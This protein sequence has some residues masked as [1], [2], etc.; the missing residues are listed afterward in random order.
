MS[1]SDRLNGIMVP[2]VT[3]FDTAGDLASESARGLIERHLEVGVT[4]FYIGGSSGEGFLQ[5]VAERC[6][7]MKFVSNVV[8][9]RAIMIAQVG[10]LSARDAHTLAS[11]AA[12]SNY[13]VVSSTPPFYFN[14]TENEIVA[15]YS[16]LA[17][18]SDLPVLLYN[19]PG[20]TGCNLST[21]AQIRMLNISNVIGSK[22]T[23]TNFLSAERLMRAVPGA[24]IFNGPDEMLTAGLAMGMAGGI[25]S[26]YNLMPRHYVD[27]YKHV[28]RGDLV[29]ARASQAIVNDL[30]FELLRISPGVIPGIKLGLG[31]LG[32]DVGGPRKPFQA[33]TADTS[34]F[35]RLLAQCGEL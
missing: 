25:G 13:D 35:E 2:L 34:E 17:E 9:G 33:I 29:A 18:L 19:V 14:Y 20:T 23:D 28:L 11:F 32:Y 7:F 10:A 24:K 3:P 21:D 12:E 31:I 4:G 22:H 30:I 5:S 15:Y 26:T 6:E 16:D 27:I 8:D 1:I